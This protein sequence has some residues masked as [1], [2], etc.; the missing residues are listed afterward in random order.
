MAADAVDITFSGQINR[1]VQF[2]SDGEGTGFQ[3]VDND[4]SG[5]RWRIR[6][7]QELGGGFGGGI[8]AGVYG[9]WQS[10][11]SP[12]SGATVK[13]GQNTNPGFTNRQANIWFSNNWGKVTLGQQSGAGDGGAEADLSGAWI[14]SSGAR[15]TYG[16]GV[17]W[18]GNNGNLIGVTT[19]GAATTFLPGNTPAGVNVLTMAS[20]YSQNDALSRYDVL[21]Y[22]SP[23]LG[24]VTLAASVGADEQWE[25]AARANGSLFGGDYSAALFYADANNSRGFKN[26]GGSASYLFGFGLN[27]TAMYTYRDG[28]DNPSSGV[29]NGFAIGNSNTYYGKIGY[30]WGNHAV[31]VDASTSEDATE[32][33]TTKSY[34]AGYVYNL[35]KPNIELYAGGI[36]HKLDT[37]S[38]VGSA[39]DIIVVT[40]GSRIRF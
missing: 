9:E 37:P 5:T 12:A 10:S 17:A 28:D 21:R 23:S 35:P 32:G 26:M 8:T 39:Q 29:N 38:G 4:A 6:G 19:G 36:L 2:L 27:I 31:A 16:G 33:F 34:S 1:A 14:V 25:A 7:S 30:R 13:G 24:P 11:S 22:D 15:T 18:R 3:F 40:T 20:T